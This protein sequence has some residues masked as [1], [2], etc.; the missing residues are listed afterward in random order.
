MFI[1]MN[2]NL[3]ARIKEI[4]YQQVNNKAVFLFENIPPKKLRNARESYATTITEDE[5]VILLY[6]DTVFGSA[7]EGFLLTT[8]RL[9]QK[10]LAEPPGA[11]DVGRIESIALDDKTMHSN[12]VVKSGEYEL[13]M[14]LIGHAKAEREA[15]L[16]LVDGIVRLLQG[17]S[18]AAGENQTTDEAQVPRPKRCRNCGAGCIEFANH[19]E[20]CGTKIG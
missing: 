10:N 2:D 20:Y 15:T 16:Q 1:V 19:C 13:H 17:D 9:Y 5:T 14:A 4:Y 6:D 11:L 3:R 8:K 12:L 7:K 18:Q